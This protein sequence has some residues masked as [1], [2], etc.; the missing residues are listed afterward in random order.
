[1]NAALP[2]VIECKP[3]NTRNPQVCD[4]YGHLCVLARERSD[5]HAYVST[6]IESH[7]IHLASD[8]SYLMF[9]IV[10]SECEL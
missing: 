8:I 2:F 6:A 1:M 5:R 7:N 3:D 9:W 4:W 10:V